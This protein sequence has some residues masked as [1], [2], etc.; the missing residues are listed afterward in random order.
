MSKTTESFDRLND[1]RMSGRELFW[2]SVAW[3]AFV[4]PLCYFTLR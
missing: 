2:A 4:F 3:A 1:P